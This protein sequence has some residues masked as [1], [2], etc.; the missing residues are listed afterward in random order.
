MGLRILR[1]M[2]GKF[3]RKRSVL[4]QALCFRHV[5]CL[6]SLGTLDN[7]KFDLFTLLER[8]ETFTLQRG[9]MDKH[10]LSVLDLNKSEP[11]PLIEPLHRA[12][13]S[14]NGPP[15]PTKLIRRER[16]GAFSPLPRCVSAFLDPD[17]LRGFLS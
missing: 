11:L 9:V 8:F 6:G 5:C 17:L 13:T 10:I 2:M 3:N 14:H 12:C 15:D 4:P 1:A 16:V 7:I